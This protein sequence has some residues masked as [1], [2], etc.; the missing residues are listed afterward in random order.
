MTRRRCACDRAVEVE[1]PARRAACR[2]RATPLDEP[3]RLY[4]AGR[5]ADG[6]VTVDVVDAAGALTARW[7]CGGDEALAVALLS[8]ATGHRPK[9]AIAAAFGREVLALLPRDAFAI[10]SQEI[11]AWLLIRAIERLER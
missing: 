5:E 8:D 9:A 6:Q 7:T 2:P 1:L 10:S 11:C 3:G 4:V